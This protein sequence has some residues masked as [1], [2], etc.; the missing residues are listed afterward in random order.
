MRSNP[1]KPTAGRPDIILYGGP[2]SGKSTQASA[3]VASL[4]AQHLNMGGLLRAF[5]KGRSAD[6]LRTKKIMFAGKLVPVRITNSL[7]ER[8]VDQT[9]SHHRI[10]FDGYPRSLAQAKFLDKLMAKTGRSVN[11]LY[12]KL[13]VKV[14]RD[15]LIKRARIEHRPDD[16][17]PSALRSRIAVFHHEAKDLLAHYR[18]TKQLIIIDGDQTVK[19]VQA[20]IAKAVSKC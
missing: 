14:A 2:G 6:A 12:I 20:A 3:L 5:V 17:D 18:K 19:Q 8:F 11:L 9:K 4:N 10:V 1:S 13:P 7:T 16:L 15:R